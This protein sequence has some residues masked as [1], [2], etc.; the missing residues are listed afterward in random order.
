MRSD[1]RSHRA[2]T[3]VAREIVSEIRDQALR[4]GAKLAPEHLLVERHRVSRA[5]VREALRYL[6]L[7]GALRVKSGPKGGPVVHEPSVGHLAGGLSLQLQFA[8][9]TF[10]SVLD[11]RRSIYPVLVAEAAHNATAD[12]MVALRAS[13]ARLRAAA[14]DSAATARE[15]CGF[16][17]LVAAASKNVVLGFLVN[18]L[19]QLSENSGIE[20]D[21]EQREA[22]AR[23]TEKIL[24]A[25][26]AGDAETAS[27]I[28]KR[29]LAAALR[30]WEKT[31]PERL[32]ARVAWIDVS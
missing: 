23:Q 30:Y 14:S 6:E 29:M 25:I 7:Q 17:E 12:D 3:R 10:R 11:A 4:P 1:D 26:E 22:S 21:L 15:A 5:T 32:N 18:A 28:S 9:A 8:Q 27:A 19:H 2:S 13:L 16:Y 31:A 20:Y 24:R